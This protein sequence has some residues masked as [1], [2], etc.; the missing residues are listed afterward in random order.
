MHWAGW[1]QNSAWRSLRVAEFMGH[2]QKQVGC[3]WSINCV[4]N[5]HHQRRPGSQPC[6]HLPSSQSHQIVAIMTH[7]LQ[8]IFPPKPRLL[9][10]HYPPPPPSPPLSCH[11]LPAPLHFPH[12]NTLLWYLQTCTRNFTVTALALHQSL[13]IQLGAPPVPIPK[14]KKPLE[15]APRRQPGLGM[16][17]SRRHS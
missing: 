2:G 10:P 16:P 11:S 15:L 3:L 1:M 4:S 8:V 9:V 14:P 6:V 7:F 13:L 17:I 12:D 5:R